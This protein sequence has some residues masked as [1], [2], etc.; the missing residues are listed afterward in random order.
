[1]S[2]SLRRQHPGSQSQLLQDQNSSEYARSRTVPHTT[3]KSAYSQTFRFIAYDP[4][5][6]YIV[7]RDI[8]KALNLRCMQVHRYDMVTTTLLQHVCH[9]L[10]RNRR[11]AFVFLVLPRIRE[12][13]NHRRDAF[14]ARNLAGMHHD[15]ELHERCVDIA[16]P[17]IDDVYIVFADGLCDPY[18]RLSD[19]IAGDIGFRNGDPKAV[20]GELA[21]RHLRVVEEGGAHRR[22]IISASSGWL[23][24]VF[25]K[26]VR[27]ASAITYTSVYPSKNIHTS[28]NFETSR[29]QHDTTRSLDRCLEPWMWEGVL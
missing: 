7:N 12:Q 9:Q 20:R 4:D 18:R 29:R 10:R 2:L 15:A 16:I 26:Y 23:V 17:C 28:E 8:E 11:A 22:A 5:I 25:E 27:N 19:S 3:E 6:S 1:M 14:C 13:R 21:R 24:P